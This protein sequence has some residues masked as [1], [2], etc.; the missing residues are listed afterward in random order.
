MSIK[1]SAYKITYPNELGCGSI[2]AIFR[3]NITCMWCSSRSNKIRSTYSTNKFC[4]VS[5]SPVNSISLVCAYVNS[6]IPVL[7]K[8]EQSKN[9]RF[10]QSWSLVGVSEVIVDVTT[11]P[12]RQPSSWSSGD[13]IQSNLNPRFNT[14]AFWLLHSIL[15]QHYS[16]C[17]LHEHG[18]FWIIFDYMSRVKL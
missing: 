4:S 17:L 18:N 8:H 16:S 9:L 11:Q 6:A 1:R 2:T 7:Q 14:V 5:I 3:T 12:T 13:R 15:A 10:T